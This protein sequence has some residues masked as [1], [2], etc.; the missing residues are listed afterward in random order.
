MLNI[1]LDVLVTVHTNGPQTA[2]FVRRNDSTPHRHPHCSKWGEPCRNGIA[3]YHPLSDGTLGQSCLVLSAL[4]TPELK[5]YA[6]LTGSPACRGVAQESPVSNSTDCLGKQRW[7]GLS[8]LYVLT[9]ALRASPIQHFE[10]L[11]ITAFLVTTSNSTPGPSFYFSEINQTRMIVES[12]SNIT[13]TLMGRSGPV[14]ITLVASSIV[15][16][17]TE[18]IVIIIGISFCNSIIR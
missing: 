16:F 10:R 9:V 18:L 11:P 8:A 13:L 12:L 1:A 17:T 3:Q 4:A 6:A 15:L 2:M 5:S 14:P 7:R